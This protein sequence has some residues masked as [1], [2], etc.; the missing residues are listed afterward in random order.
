MFYNAF[1]GDSP[2]GGHKTKHD[3]LY[4][5]LYCA[6]HI[7][8][9]FDL[10]TFCLMECPLKTTIYIGWF[11]I[12]QD[13]RTRLITSFNGYQKKQSLSNNGLGILTVGKKWLHGERYKFYMPI[14]DHDNKIKI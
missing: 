3:F 13:H 6:H 10:V 9:S 12:R 14:N 7:L 8:Y 1:F 4:V 11:I 5:P 2:I